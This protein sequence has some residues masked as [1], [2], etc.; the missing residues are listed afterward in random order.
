MKK[1]NIRVH[2][3]GGS[4][5]VRSQVPNKPE[6]ARSLTPKNAPRFEGIVKWIDSETQ[7][8]LIEVSPEVAAELKIGS[9]NS[10][11]FSAKELAEGR[12]RDLREGGRVSF[13]VESNG[14]GRFA[15]KLKVILLA[16]TGKSAGWEPVDCEFIKS[17][18]ELHETKRGDSL[19]RD[20]FG[21]L[22][23]ERKVLNTSGRHACREFRHVSFADACHWLVNQGHEMIPEVFLAR[24]GILEQARLKRR[25]EKIV[26]LGMDSAV[27]QAFA[28]IEL[29]EY[30][31]TKEDDGSMPEDLK[32]PF[33]NGLINL[34]SH[35]QTQL[36]AL[37]EDYQAAMKAG[38]Q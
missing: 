33:T 2:C 30:P 26:A 36:L 13:C 15:A 19:N 14:R 9:E 38:V 4:K 21:R 27:D 3:N 32:Q 24:H 29:M 1:T 6:S 7:C 23:V 28:L 12:D 22:F 18:I 17:T 25:D 31:L 20:A 10:L 8:G 35:V 16:S 37:K 5:S 11:V 34:T